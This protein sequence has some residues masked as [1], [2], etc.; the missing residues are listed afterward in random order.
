MSGPKQGRPRP[1]L[2]E[3]LHLSAERRAR[4]IMHTTT[5][6]LEDYIEDSEK[7]V[8]INV[9][10][11]G[12]VVYFELR[13]R[14]EQRMM[15]IYLANM[16]EQEVVEAV[17]STLTTVFGDTRN[18]L[19]PLL[20][21]GTV[22][23]YSDLYLPPAIGEVLTFTR[24]TAHK[25]FAIPYVACFNCNFRNLV[26]LPQL[27]PRSSEALP[28]PAARV[29]LQSTVDKMVGGLKAPQTAMHSEHIETGML[30]AEGEG[31]SCRT[32]R[33]LPTKADVPKAAENLVKQEN[34]GGLGLLS[35]KPKQN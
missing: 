17:N 35:K 10:Q 34:E 24:S 26:P 18:D 11:K 16:D 8:Q 12:I 14:D 5:A 23:D 15:D 28:V 31:S 19:L 6:E 4:G 20:R 22:Y 30:A 9:G 29:Q 21:K 3:Q 13:L 2:L 25:H 32:K 33:A 27:L 1:R 7:D